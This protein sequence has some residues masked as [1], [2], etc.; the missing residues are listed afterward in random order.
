MDGDRTVKIIGLTASSLALWLIPKAVDASYVWRAAFGFTALSVC[1]T[2]VH[3]SAK[4]QELEGFTRAEKMAIKER[5]ATELAYSQMAFESELQQRLGMAQP[6][7]QQPQPQPQLPPH[8]TID[9]ATGQTIEPRFKL[10]MVQQSASSHLLFVGPTGSGKTTIAKYIVCT[11]FGTDDVRVYDPDDDTHTWGYFPVCGQ[12]D[13]WTEIAGSMQGDLAEF[14]KRSRLRIARKPLNTYC[15][16]IIDE[17]PDTKGHVDGADEWFETLLR[18]GRK[19]KMF[20]IGLCTDKSVESLKI[21]G[22]SKLLNNFTAV[23]LGAEAHDAMGHLSNNDEKQYYRHLLSQCDRPAMVK[24]EGRWYVWDVPDLSRWEMP[25]PSPVQVEEARL[26]NEEA[27]STPQ[28]NQQGMGLREQLE[29]M[30]SLPEAQ[31]TH[32][33]T[34]DVDLSNLPESAHEF[35]RYCASKNL[36]GQWVKV[37]DIRKNWGGNKGIKGDDLIAILDTL[38]A[39]GWGQWEDDTRR[40]WMPTF[41]PHDV[42]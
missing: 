19:R 21:Q 33:E 23:Y 37:R 29:T 39:S 28:T 42:P 2:A 12:D 41:S 24:H 35:L 32:E 11:L 30:W 31:H 27:Q 18:R 3:E 4:E 8:I 38:T 40:A 9:V 25:D 15:I 1:L 14:S 5:H 13:D 22:K 36:I 10:E 6:Q 20:I 34:H 17:M 16:R 26:F 7:Q